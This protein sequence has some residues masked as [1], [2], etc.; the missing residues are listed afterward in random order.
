MSYWNKFA[1]LLALVVLPFGL[2]FSQ[3][4]HELPIPGVGAEF[5][6]PGAHEL[7]DPQMTYKVVFDVAAE[8]QDVDEINPGL[9]FVGRFVNTLAKHGVSLEHRQ[10]ALVLHREATEVIL[11]N[12]AF[13]ARHDGRDN[14][15]LEIIRSLVNAGVDIRQCGQAL[16]GRDID[17]ETVLPEIQ[18]DYWALTTLLKLQSEGYVKV[19][20]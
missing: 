3:A 4:T 19:G 20:G 1:A 13:Q 9:A 16:I 18:I 17:P 8:A 15:N 12:P 6:V 14:P 2:S 7:P 10:I 11:K 5:D